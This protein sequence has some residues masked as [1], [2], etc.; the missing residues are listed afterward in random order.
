MPRPAADRRASGGRLRERP[1]AGRLPSHLA[2]PLETA[3]RRPG[4]GMAIGAL[5]VSASAVLLDLAHTTPGT[6]SFYRCVLALP[7]LV[8]L[9]GAEHRR[10]GAPPRRRYAL[11][12]AAGVL[13]AGDMLLW[14]QAIAEVGAGLSTVLVNVQVVL[15]PLIAWAVDREPVPAR[16]LGWL[17][18]LLMGVV[19][20]GGVLERRVSVGTDPRWGTAHAVLAAVCYSGFLYLL[21]R[22]GHR[23]QVRQTYT[24]VIASA[25][26]VSLLAG[27]AWYGFDVTPGWR[28]LGWLLA[29]AVTSQ[30]VGW[31]LVA[32]AS[33]KLASHVG[34]ILLLLTPV[35]AVALG[36]VVLGE[37]PT[38]LQLTGCVL[39]LI[40][41]YFTTARKRPAENAPDGRTARRPG[42][43]RPEEAGTSPRPGR[44][45]DAGD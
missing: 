9:A 7:A 43:S 37:R 23:G 31:L 35:G 14:T 13:F 5:C 34:A 44:G 30:V 24:V 45:A 11:A 25:A 12:F 18:L 16:F 40:S 3:V 33:P 38:P 36:A 19:L 6:A 1:P 17:P 41:A 32:T 42:G 28:V 2:H 8:A 29:V 27:P 15:V 4:W 39:I 26:V 20:T 22:A 10:E 21:R